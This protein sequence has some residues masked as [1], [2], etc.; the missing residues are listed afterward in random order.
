MRREIQ[1]FSQTPHQNCTRRAAEGKAPGAARTT[2]RTFPPFPPKGSQNA[3]LSPRPPAKSGCY[4][5]GTFKT[6][7]DRHGIC[8]RRSC[9]TG[10]DASDK[11]S[12]GDGGA[13]RAESARTEEGEAAFLRPLLRRDGTLC[14]L[15]TVCGDAAPL[16]GGRDGRRRAGYDDGKF[17]LRHGGGAASREPAAGRQ[18]LYGAPAALP[19]S[20]DG[21]CSV[22]ARLLHPRVCGGAHGAEAHEPF[23]DA[24]PAHVREFF[25]ARLFGC[26]DD[27]RSARPRRPL[28]GGR[29]AGAAHPLRGGTAARERARERP[30]PPLCRSGIYGAVPAADAAQNRAR[31]GSARPRAA[32]GAEGH[33]PRPPPCGHGGQPSLEHPSAGSGESVSLRPH[34]LF[35][36]MRGGRLG[37]RRLR[38]GRDELFPVH[39]RASSFAARRTCGALRARPVG[40]APGDP[41]RAEETRGE[42]GCVKGP[43]ERLKGSNRLK[44]P[45]RCKSGSGSGSC[46]AGQW[47][48]RSRRD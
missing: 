29:R 46:P 45:S 25:G 14:R 20:D 6:G 40:S 1:G 31:G 24:R 35:G 12:A 48:L 43:K 42:K 28:Y 2:K 13:P 5:G 47:A 32:V 7:G 34:P 26:G 9:F 41:L 4:N 33:R 3:T 39:R 30:A 22:R 21:R 44:G 10:R 11:G 17:A 19:P 8:G 15:R 16:F 38:C 36:A 37:L 23:L 18:P 27:A